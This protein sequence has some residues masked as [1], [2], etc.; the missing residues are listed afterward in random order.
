MSISPPSDIVLDVARAADPKRAAAAARRLQDI[1]GETQAM[2]FAALLPQDPTHSSMPVADAS[3]HAAALSTPPAA[4][5]LQNRDPYSAL[6]GLVLQK[7][8]ENMLPSGSAA[9]FGKGAAGAIWKSALAEQMTNAISA[10]VF[11]AG[12]PKG[13]ETP[14]EK[15]TGATAEALARA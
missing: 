9:T 11:K 8:I 5:P 2:S 3:S 12:A 15:A 6:G 4:R 14:G 7:A 10:S 1:A 13:M